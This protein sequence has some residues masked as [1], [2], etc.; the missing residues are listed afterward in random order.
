MRVT[1]AVDAEQ[2]MKRLWFMQRSVIEYAE[3]GVCSVSNLIVP[4]TI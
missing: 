3:D 2:A 1:E 4:V